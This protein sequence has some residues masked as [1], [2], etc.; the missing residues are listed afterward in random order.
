MKQITSNT[1]LIQGDKSYSPI[2]V[3]EGIIW[4]DISFP[5]LEEYPKM[6]P[7]AA[8]FDLEGI[9]KIELEDEVEKLARIEYEK[10]LHK[11][12]TYSDFVLAFS[13]G[14]KA[15]QAKYTE[16]DIIKCWCAAIDYVEWLNEPTIQNK[17]PKPFD[18][19]QYLQ[20]L[21]SI[22]EITVDENFKQI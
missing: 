7:L 5:I 13:I 12:I 15:N 14:Y 3:K 8:N 2:E 1:V 18:R 19:V 22:K 9:P 10:I 20:S 4:V 21:N 6:N 16:E 17:F 11:H